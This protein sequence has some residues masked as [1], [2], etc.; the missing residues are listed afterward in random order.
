M[1]R[2]REH[3][4]DHHISYV[5]EDICRERLMH[6][7]LNLMKV[8]RYWEKDIEIDL[9]GINED[10]RRIVFGECKYWIGQV[11]MNIM[12]ALQEK[13]KCVRWHE[14]DREEIFVLFSIHGF[15][16][17]LKEYAAAKEN[18]RLMQ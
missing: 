7:D 15:T 3:L 13:S 17:E 16:K 9:L 8:G 2:I 14:G 5:Y 1:K 18:I 6:L 4:I 11:G 12:T 10:E